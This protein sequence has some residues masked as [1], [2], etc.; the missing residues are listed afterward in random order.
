MY[1]MNERIERMI[2]DVKFVLFI[3]HIFFFVKFFLVNVFYLDSRGI[4]LFRISIFCFI[5]FEKKKLG[6]NRRHIFCN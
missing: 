1:G 4:D 3:F 2:V 6:G 5:V